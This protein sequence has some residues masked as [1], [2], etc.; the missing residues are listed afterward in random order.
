[1]GT[2]QAMYFNTL[3]KDLHANRPGMSMQGLIYISFVLANY[4]IGKTKLMYTYNL[5]AQEYDSTPAACERAVRRWITGIDPQVLA[6]YL[7]LNTLTD[8]RTT[9]IIPLLKATIDTK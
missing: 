9:S 6:N 3:L 2:E 8:T 5:V 4:E 7:G 1:M